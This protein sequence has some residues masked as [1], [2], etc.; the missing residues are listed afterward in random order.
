MLACQPLPMSAAS[1]RNERIARARARLATKLAYAPPEF[2]AP[3][4]YHEDVTL[5]TARN[6]VD[7]LATGRVSAEQAVVSYGRRLLAAHAQTNCLTDL[8]LEEALVRAR[9]LDAHFRATGRPVGKLHGVPISVKDMFSVAGSDTTLGYSAFIDQPRPS[10]ALMVDI[11][12]HEGAI[13][14]A[15]TNVPQ[16]MMSFECSNPV[17]GRTLNPHN[18]KFSPGGS[19]GG[20]AALLALRGAAIGV[21]TDAAG[22]LRLPAHFSGIYSLKPS[23]DRFPLTGTFTIQQGQ[24]NFKTVAG[25]MGNSVED[26]HLFCESVLQ[27]VHLRRD[28][29]AVPV[30][31]NPTRGQARL[32]PAKA[33]KDPLEPCV[34]P[35]VWAL[36][37]P[38]WMRTMLG[39][40]IENLG[41]PTIGLSLKATR[42]KSVRDVHSAVK[43]RDA[44]RAAFHDAW[45]ALDLDFMVCPVSAMVANPH[46]TFVDL[47][48]TASHTLLY[49]LLDYTAG[50]VPVTVVKPTDTIDDVQSVKG[51][52]GT[53][54][55]RLHRAINRIYDPKAMAGLPVGVQIVGRRFEEERVIDAMYEVVRCLA[56]V[57]AK[58]Y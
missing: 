10:N 56:A 31:W 20:E 9:H 16:M 57:Q 29:H 26:L 54:Q 47:A 45:Q 49:N 55:D 51:A 17:F 52:Q 21:G 5:G 13:I 34:T 2:L 14:I 22:S 12:L 39:N 18:R 41:E 19:S 44:Y 48:N 23:A 24:E 50:T 53:E 4:I 32:A 38:Q 11:L 8:F 35:L 15:K 3:Y 28:P 1:R 36:R 46:K 42:N 25:P 30:P 27:D 40:V 6:L 33:A 37:L 58:Q 43:D 7:G